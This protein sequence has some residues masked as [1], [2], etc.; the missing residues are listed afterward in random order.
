MQ[1]YS[2]IGG[3]LDLPAGEAAELIAKGWI[4]EGSPGFVDRYALKK[5]PLAEAQKPSIVE[6]QSGGTPRVGRPRRG[7][8][9]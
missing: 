8:T 9:P 1:I 5:Q 2:P 3:Y 4:A 7:S 6:A